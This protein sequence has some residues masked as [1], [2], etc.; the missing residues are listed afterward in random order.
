M[1]LAVGPDIHYVRNRVTKTPISCVMRM[2]DGDKMFSEQMIYP[3]MFYRMASFE[4]SLCRYGLGLSIR[5]AIVRTIE[6]VL[7]GVIQKRKERYIKNGKQLE[8]MVRHLEQNF[9]ESG[10]KNTV[11]NVTCLGLL[12]I[13]NQFVCGPHKLWF[14][15]RFQEVI[16]FLLESSEGTYGCLCYLAALVTKE[17]FQTSE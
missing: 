15:S 2:I 10:L 4:C 8:N 17:L 1:I 7:R 9:I 6:S 14:G 13:E 3:C 16:P 12:K 5:D 11:Q